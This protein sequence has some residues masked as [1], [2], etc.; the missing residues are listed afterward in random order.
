[1]VKFFAKS[2][3]YEESWSTVTL[4]FF[5]RYPN[6]HAA[7][8]LSCDVLSRTHTSEGTLVTKRLMLKRGAVP[9]WLPRGIVSRAESWIVEDSEVDP[10]GKVVRC[11]TRNL[12][13]VKIL[14]VKE[15][16]EL[17]E[18]TNGSTVHKTEARVVSN[19]GWGL[20]KRIERY[21]HDKFERNLERSRAGISL[22]LSL[23]RD[24]RLRTLAN[25]QHDLPLTGT[26]LDSFRP[27]LFTSSLGSPSTSI[28]S[29]NSQPAPSEPIRSK[30]WST[31]GSDQSGVTGNRISPSSTGKSRWNL[32]AWLRSSS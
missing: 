22:I 5:L 17:R 11:T 24:A 6:P 12:D 32:F 25:E 15:D 28:H 23:I 8:V 13:H 4:A 31:V 29:I 30:R 19:F 16:V 18:A 2:H 20:A 9:K 27:R 26:V 7:H 3:I 10:W 14:N 21:G 1:M